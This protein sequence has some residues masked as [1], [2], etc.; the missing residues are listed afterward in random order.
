LL[1]SQDQTL[2]TL[3]YFFVF[4]MYFALQHRFLTLSLSSVVSALATNMSTDKFFPLRLTGSSMKEI[5]A[6]FPLGKTPMTAFKI[7]QLSIWR[8]F[9]FGDKER[10]KDLTLEQDASP[11]LESIIA[12]ITTWGG[13]SNIAM[14]VYGN[15]QIIKSKVPQMLHLLWEFSQAL[16]KD[17]NTPGATLTFAEVYK[18]LADK[19]VPSLPP[20]GIIIWLLISDFVEYGICFAPTEQDLAEH[21]IPIAKGSHGSP[22]GPTAAL[23]YAA[24]SAEEEMPN[25]AAALTKVLRKIIEVFNNPTEAM[26]TI[27]MLVRVCKEIQGRNLNMV[28]IE[29]ALCKIARQ[30][31]M[32]K[33]RESK[34]Q[35]A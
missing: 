1:C 3:I 4:T 17:C 10:I 22:S 24:E 11:D 16:S 6:I 7:F 8:T 19:K 27:Q 14:P 2:H 5:I 35:K 18:R 28:D 23:K 20:G 32:G 12:T 21:I 34:K 30:L 31:S 25:D 33:G 26:P 9:A 29:H 13:K 15:F